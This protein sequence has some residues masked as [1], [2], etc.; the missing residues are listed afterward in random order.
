M[1]TTRDT[2]G[3]FYAN[4]ESK[5]F[6]A[7]RD[8][9]DEDLDFQSPIDHFD[10]A[11][12]LIAKL[13]KLSAVTESFQVKHLFVDGD[14]ACCVY[15]LVTATPL[16]ESPAT[17]YFELRDGRITSIRAHYDSRPWAALFAKGGE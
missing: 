2:I 9:L 16:R 4:I 14:R 1:P 10:K 17:E 7:L 15:D 11:E 13:T 6:D 8:L 3:A 5:S 12:H